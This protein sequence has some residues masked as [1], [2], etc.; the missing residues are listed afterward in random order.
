MKHPL[1]I[2]QWGTFVQSDMRHGIANL[3]IQTE[4]VN[5]IPEK[6]KGRCVS[7]IM[8]PAGNVVATA[9]AAG[10]EIAPWASATL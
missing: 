2:A 9:P 4:L 10:F 5:D 8:D 7:R 3:S 1:H 6:A